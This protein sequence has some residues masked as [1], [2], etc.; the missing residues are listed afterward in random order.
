MRVRPHV[1]HLL[2]M[3]G[4]VPDLLALDH[5]SAAEHQMVRDD[6]LAHDEAGIAAIQPV[7]IG[8]VVELDDQPPRQVDAAPAQLRQLGVQ[9]GLI[10]QPR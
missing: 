10:G 7:G 3:V 9:L 1:L 6:L 8:G 2:F 5:P 4:V